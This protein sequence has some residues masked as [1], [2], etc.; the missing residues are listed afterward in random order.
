M[1]TDPAPLCA[2][3]GTI[4]R[5]RLGDTH[6]TCDPA[7][8]RRRWDAQVQAVLTRLATQTGRR[9]GYP[10][11]PPPVAAPPPPSQRR[12]TPDTPLRPSTAARAGAPTHAALPLLALMAGAAA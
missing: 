11:T 1:T 6:P 10:A 4:M 3:Y 12:P 2:D 7:G 9:A 8:P 5:P